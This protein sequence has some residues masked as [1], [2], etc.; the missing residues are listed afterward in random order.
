VLAMAT[1]TLRN[2]FL[3]S[4]PSD[5]HSFLCCEV[6]GYATEKEESGEER[7]NRVVTNRV[8]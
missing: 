1:Y 5:I 3:F 2:H 4:H 8:D 7:H 6:E